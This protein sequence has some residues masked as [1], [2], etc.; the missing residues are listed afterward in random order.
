MRAHGT[1]RVR[2]VTVATAQGEV[3][4]DADALV[5]DAPAAPAYELAVQA[6][7]RVRPEARGFVVDAPDG[8]VR[9]GVYAVGEVCGV[10]L[11]AA[12]MAAHVASVVASLASRAAR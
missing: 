12:V 9:P 4:R 3:E 10:P 11:D 2:R 7:A 8:C 6:G 5:V 1:T